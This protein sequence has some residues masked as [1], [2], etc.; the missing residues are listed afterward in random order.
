MMNR[1]GQ[2]RPAAWGLGGV[3]LNSEQV[4]RS[5]ESVPANAQVGATGDGLHSAPDEKGLSTSELI[6]LLHAELR[7]LAAAR[8][9]KERPGHTLSPTELVH[10]VYLRLDGEG[11]P[12]RSRA[13]F[14][15]A[16][17]EAMRRILI[18]SAEAKA[19]IKRGG[20]RLRV[21]IDNDLAAP[22][23][24]VLL[25]F[26]GITGL[27][28]EKLDEALRELAIE[29]PETYWTVMLRYFAGLNETLTA[30]MLETS[31]RTVRRRWA[32]A[33]VVLF[34]KCKSKHTADSRGAI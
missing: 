11:H 27:D 25:D 29:S 17:A 33:K 1:G 3:R 7:K 18:E 28:P 32:V 30:E 6:Q 24:S 26:D 31:E 19:T 12:W 13:Q 8:M 9:R 22:P 14:F 2:F 15:K 23:Q 4:S 16:A 34:D 21:P 20:G 10:E 5:S